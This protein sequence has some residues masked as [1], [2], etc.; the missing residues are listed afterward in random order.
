MMEVDTQW[1]GGVAL[2]VETPPRPRAPGRPTCRVRTRRFGALFVSQRQGWQRSLVLNFNF[3]VL[4]KHPLDSQH[5]VATRAPRR[6][7]NSVDLIMELTSPLT[8]LGSISTPESFYTAHDS[9]SNGADDTTLSSPVDDV[10]LWEEPTYRPAAQ[11]PRELRQ[12]CQ[13]HLEEELC[14]LPA[15]LFQSQ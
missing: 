11:L 8:T 2:R 5:T 9:A 15:L 7:G 13:I 10:P 4:Q 6:S 1:I 12:H 3:Q 14:R